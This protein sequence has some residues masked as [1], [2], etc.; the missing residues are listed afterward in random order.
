M[1]AYAFMLSLSSFFPYTLKERVIN[2]SQ[3]E[4]SSGFLFIYIRK[5]EPVNN[6]VLGVNK[7]EAVHK[8][9]FHRM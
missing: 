1:G 7:A 9:R 8:K 5:A 6:D 3:A 4:G 2:C